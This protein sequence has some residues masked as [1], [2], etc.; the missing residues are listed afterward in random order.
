M[1][2][3]ERKLLEKISG[4]LSK[5][6]GSRCTIYSADVLGGGTLHRTLKISA[7]HGNFFLK[8]SNSAPSDIFLREAESLLYMRS[9]KADH[10]IIPDVIAADSVGEEPGYLL[11]GFLNGGYNSQNDLLLGRGLASLHLRTLSTQFGFF[12]TTYCGATLQD[13]S[14]SKS[15]PE[16]YARQRIGYLVNRLSLSQR[17]S[18]TDQ[19]LMEKFIDR[20]PQLL[21]GDRPASL[22]HGDLW[23]GNY[24]HTPDGPALIDPAAYFADCEM[25]FGMVTLFGG[26]SKL[27]WSGYQE[28][29]P[30]LP[31]WQ[32]RIS[33]YQSYH[34]LNHMLLFG[35]AYRE[36]LL[37]IIRRYI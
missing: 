33:I 8:W 36:S 17:L 9:V 25:E 12:H 29:N 20:L 3:D 34:L 15:W 11:L 24:L 19:N 5:K 1:I 18:V 22:I 27:F 35:D 13:N 14:W 37:R 30:L 32:E 26:F 16:F 21:P 10:L 4:L 7:S 23:S 2:T 28:V 31:D 6:T